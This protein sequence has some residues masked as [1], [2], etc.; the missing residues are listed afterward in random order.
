[1]QNTLP[2]YFG[3]YGG[4][5]VPETLMP[6]LEEFE[7]TVAVNVVI[8]VWRPDSAREARV[9]SAPREVFKLVDNVEIEPFKVATSAASFAIW[10]FNEEVIAAS[11]AKARVTSEER[12]DEIPADVR[13]AEENLY[14]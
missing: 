7:F 10:A 3:Q 14:S 6:A 2:K 5:Y 4:Q 12:L 8:W 9:T 1:M 11:A 13:D